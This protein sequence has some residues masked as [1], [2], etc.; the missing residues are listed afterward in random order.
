MIFLCRLFKNTS[1]NFLEIP[2]SSGEVF[3]NEFA[4]KK[5]FDS[6]VTTMKLEFQR[7][8]NRFDALEAKFVAIDNRFDSLDARFKKIDNRFE[9]MEARFGGIDN[10]FNSLENKISKIL[11]LIEERPSTQLINAV[12]MLALFV[13]F[14][15][16]MAALLPTLL[17]IFHLF[18]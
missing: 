13:G 5:D 17:K 6:L 18:S 9:A 4:T 10:R 3:V 15:L 11:I 14:A 12:M 7:V 1:I 2:I 16:T 8:D